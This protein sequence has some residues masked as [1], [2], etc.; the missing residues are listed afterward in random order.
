MAD[1][2]QT[3]PPIVPPGVGTPPPMQAP[4]MDV[5][6]QGATQM[7]QMQSPAAAVANTVPAAQPAQITPE[8]HDNLFG[9]AAKMLMGNN[10][11][12]SV[13]ADG[14]TVATQTPTQPGSLWKNILSAAILGGA[15]GTNSNGSFAQGA[16]QG[17]AAV[18]SHA[19]QQDQ[20]KRQQ[21]QEDFRNSQEVDKANQQK[22]LTA[23]T[24]ANMHAETA[25][26]QQTTDLLSKED[27]DKHNAATAALESGLRTAGGVDAQIPVNG[28]PKSDMTAPE[29]GVAYAQDPSIRNGPDGFTRHFIDT[30]DSSDVTFNGVHWVTADGSPVNMTDKTTIKAIDV[31]DNA[32]NKKQ[33]MTG[34]QLNQISGN[35]TFDPKKMYQVSPQESDDLNTKRIANEQKMALTNLE[36]RKANIEAARVH[37]ESARLNH[38]FDTEKKNEFAAAAR[39]V[40]ENVRSL[41]A[42]AKDPMLDPKLKQHLNDQINQ[43]NANLAKYYDKAYPGMNLGKMA[44]EAGA[45]PVEPPVMMLNPQGQQVSVPKEKMDAAVKAG[46]KQQGVAAPTDL[47]Q[48]DQ[49]TTAVQDPKSGQTFSVPDAGVENFLKQAPGAKIIG[50]GTRQASSFWTDNSS[51]NPTSK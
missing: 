16:A 41:Q 21:A 34:Y 20:L 9:K 4:N 36:E 37:V 11:T 18:I 31:P 42:Q 35:S 29:L 1:P 43:A 33:P 24:V 49:G 39:M 32:M 12:Y 13:G 48:F 47:G 5:A 28:V 51:S 44:V 19:E 2:I 14:K 46:Y 30:T 8:Q 27:H 22:T 26:R 40:S 45:A 3:A 15:A 23:A 10:T 6:S 17:G 7:G 25:A 50:K 38:E